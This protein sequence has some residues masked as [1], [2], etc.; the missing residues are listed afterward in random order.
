MEIE[1]LPHETVWNI[2]ADPPKIEAREKFRCLFHRD[3]DG[4]GDMVVSHG[5]VFTFELGLHG[6][7]EKQSNA[8]DIW[9]RCHDCGWTTVNGVA[10]PGDLY[11]ELINTV[12]NAPRINEKGERVERK[13]EETI[14]D[15]PIGTSATI[16]VEDKVERPVSK[17]RELW[18]GT[19]DVR[20]LEP[21]FDI[22]CKYCGREAP[23]FLRHSKLNL[24]RRDRTYR[25][26]RLPWPLKGYEIK[27]VKPRFKEVAVP[28]FRVS[29]KCPHCDWLPTFVV[30]VEKDYFDAT[31]DL[32][33][34]EPLYYPPLD[35]WEREAK[36]TAEEELIHEKLKS[37][38]YV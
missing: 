16:F 1:K 21:Q 25:R 3:L 6:D 34:G 36:G 27:L 31:L 33:D 23:M 2:S 37:L 13:P 35:E 4:S 7:A 8:V 17:A 5:E 10:I 15:I 22:T 38:G 29:Y 14:K 9:S 19:G 30:P 32:R 26:L 20:G 24:I 28:A 12:F 11:F 18:K